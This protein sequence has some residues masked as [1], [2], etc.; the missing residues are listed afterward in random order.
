MHLIL[1][2]IVGIAAGISA[3]VQQ[4]LVASLRANIGSATWAILISYVGGTL[5]MILV[6]LVM[7]EPWLST[8]G[9][10][11]SSWPSIAAG[12]FGVVYLVL[13]VLL[14]PRLGAATVLALLV[15]GQLLASLT[16]DHFGLF[17]LPRQP[18]DVS[19]IAGAL[20]LLGGVALIRN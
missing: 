16:M 1:L 2:Y 6:L 7:R 4:V 10:A 12:A 3:V 15:A 5:T 8:A 17:G 11:K 19:R 20:M 18:A 9:L 13:A 14:I